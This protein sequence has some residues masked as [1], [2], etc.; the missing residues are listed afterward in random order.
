MRAS[1]NRITD[2][3]WTTC[4]QLA[5][6]YRNRNF[7]ACYFTKEGLDHH[8][9]MITLGGHSHV[10]KVTGRDYEY[11]KDTP[12]S[13][14]AWLCL[15]CCPESAASW[16]LLISGVSLPEVSLFE[17]WTMSLFSSLILGTSGQWFSTRAGEGCSIPCPIL[18]V[19]TLVISSVLKVIQGT[20]SNV[21]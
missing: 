15:S 7:Q 10:T 5:E 21:H 13:F 1:F 8:K 9:G 16:Q 2:G 4:R 19:I 18:S 6:E 14:I 3:D 20:T 17:M 12:N 11:L